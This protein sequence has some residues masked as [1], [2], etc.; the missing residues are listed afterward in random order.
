LGPRLRGDDV[1]YFGALRRREQQPLT[2]PVIPAQAGTQSSRLENPRCAAFQNAL[3]PRLRGDDGA[4]F[5]ALRRRE[6]QPLTCPVIPAQAGTQS[7]RIEKPRCA[8]F[9][10]ALGPRLRGDDGAYFGVKPL[11][12]MIL[13]QLWV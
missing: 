13:S 3:G 7:A 4:Y 12:L 9:L 5:G 6:Q 2:C 1:A 10:N 11:A 8:G